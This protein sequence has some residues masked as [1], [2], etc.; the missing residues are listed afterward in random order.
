MAPPN[1]S[2][3]QPGTKEDQNNSRSDGYKNS[4]SN[5]LESREQQPEPYSDEDSY[6]AARIDSLV[7]ETESL[8]AEVQSKAIGFDN[9]TPEQLRNIHKDA[10]ERE[11][12][13]QTRTDGFISVL[14]FG[15]P[16]PPRAKRIL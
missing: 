15:R 6:R 14:R 1:E 12:W 9:A 13:S 3:S 5:D 8:L 16:T 10:T 11:G 4:N 2:N 7:G